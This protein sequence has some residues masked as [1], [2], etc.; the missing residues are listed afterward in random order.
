M[1]TNAR[2]WVR[3]RV[4]FFAFLINTCDRRVVFERNGCD[5]GLLDDEDICLEITKPLKQS[6]FIAVIRTKEKAAAAEVIN[7]AHFIIKRLHGDCYLFS[8]GDLMTVANFSASKVKP[9]EEQLQ[10]WAR[11]PRGCGET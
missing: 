5:Y 2:R 11:S 8:D 6:S 4:R 3:L 7:S 1:K 9:A 10:K